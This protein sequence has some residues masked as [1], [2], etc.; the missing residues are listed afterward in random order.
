[1][2][3]DGK[4][5]FVLYCD[6][7]HTVEL[8]DDASAGK[9]LKHLLQYVNDKNPVTT[10]Q[11]IKIAFE[12]IKQQLKRDLRDWEE[13][14]EKRVKAGHEG[15]LKSGESRRSKANG[16]SASILKQKEAKGSK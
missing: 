9:L 8:L 2:M 12:P 1:M 13:T 16:A 7:M 11:I 6:M 14:R 10:D 15:G 3:A 5:S 4:K